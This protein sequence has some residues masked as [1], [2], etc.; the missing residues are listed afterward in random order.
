MSEMGHSRRFR[1]VGRESALPTRTDIV[2]E[3]GH[4][5]KVPT[6][7]SSTAAIKTLLLHLA[8]LRLC[9]SLVSV[10]RQ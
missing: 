5:G 3:T 6:R 7:D 9:G 10:S 4:V 8:L 2:S 1:D